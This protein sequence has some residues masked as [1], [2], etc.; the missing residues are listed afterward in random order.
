MCSNSSTGVQLRVRH[1]SGFVNSDFL[2][3]CEVLLT[4]TSL[5]T[6][7][8]LVNQLIAY[9]SIL[10]SVK[11]YDAVEVSEAPDYLRLCK[12]NGDKR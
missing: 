11:G 6:L 12:A 2:V 1:H 9:F 4:W 10:L 7:P 5:Y 3:F 8:K